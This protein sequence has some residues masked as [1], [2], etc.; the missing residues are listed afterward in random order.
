[1]KITRVEWD[2][3]WEEIVDR[4]YIDES[5]F[6]DEDP[7]PEVFDGDASLFRQSMEEKEND[8]WIFSHRERDEGVAD[9]MDVF[10]RWKKRRRVGVL[11]VEVPIEKIQEAREAIQKLGAIVK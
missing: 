8:K 5:T 7:M 3:F 4:W 2:S 1:M 10:R 6:P 11:I 9:F